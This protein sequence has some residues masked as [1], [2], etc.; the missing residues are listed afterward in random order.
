MATLVVTIAA[1]GAV[2]WFAYLVGSGTKRGGKDP[3][4]ANLSAAQTDDELETSRLDRSLVAAVVTAGFLTLSMPIYYLGELDRQEGFVEEFGDAAIERGHHVWDEFACA[5][6]HGADGSGGGAAF[7]EER[8]QVNV[9]SWAAPSIN[10]VFFR[11]DR[12]EVAFW[13]TYGRA[14]TPMPAW[15]LDG[16]GPLNSQQISDLLSYLE[17]I[18][19]DQTTALLKIEGAITGAESRLASSAESIATQIVAQ[20]ELIASIGSSGETSIV[21]AE[22]AERARGILDGAEDGIDSDGDG[23]S[24]VTESGLVAI[25]EEAVAVDLIAAAVAF[26]PRAVETLTGTADAKAAANLVG[27]L[28]STATSLTITSENKQVL[29]EQAEFGLEFLQNAAA[30]ASWEVDLAAVAAA[31]F[32]GD[33]AAAARAV[34]LFNAYCARCHTAGYSAGPAFQ[35]AQ[36][37]GAL[38]PSLRDGRALTQFLET[39]DMI[40]FLEIGSEN[41]VAYGVNGVGSGRM[42]GWGMV[43]SADDIELIVDYLRGPTLDGASQGSGE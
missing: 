16:G 21:A 33:E 24:D 34:A 37:T 43:L 9:A 8:S 42:P 20:E 13:V 31:S 4:P 19:V 35:Q 41:G 6:C 39:A 12:D 1:L 11:Y 15:G 7:L 26:D 29:I 36:A 40:E 23:L 38:G 28:E 30:N 3:V 2:G 18:Q 5:G 32:D 17:D 25:S 10:D 27:D 22:I 14:N